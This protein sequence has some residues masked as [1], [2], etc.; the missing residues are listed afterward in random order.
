MLCREPC[1]SSAG[2]KDMNWEL[3]EWLPLIDDRAFLPWLVAVPPAD[4]A[5]RPVSAT[6]INKLE[7]L[8]KQNNSATLEDLSKVRRCRYCLLLLLSVGV[9]VVFICACVYC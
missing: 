2:L 6:Q 5:V 8:W 1:A 3:K 9:D 4:A 7:E